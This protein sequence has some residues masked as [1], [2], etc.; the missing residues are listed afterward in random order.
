MNLTHVKKSYG[1]VLSGGEKR[2]L[3]IGLELVAV[4]INTIVN[5][6]GDSDDGS[7]NNDNNNNNRLF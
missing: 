2:R 4:D 1:K 5:N 7:N 6:Y 3:A